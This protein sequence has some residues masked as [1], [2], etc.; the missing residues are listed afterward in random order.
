M[1][2]GPNLKELLELVFGVIGFVVCMYFII[3]KC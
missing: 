2:I 1:E 3:T